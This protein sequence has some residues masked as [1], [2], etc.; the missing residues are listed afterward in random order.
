LIPFSYLSTGKTLDDGT[1]GGGIWNSLATDGTGVY[2]TTGNTRYCLSD[3][4]LEPVPNH[5]LGMIRVDKDTGDIAWS[6]QPVPFPLDSDPDWAAGATVM[7][8]SC[9]EQIASVQK[10]GWTYAVDATT[11][12]CN[13]AFPPINSPLADQN[14][15]TCKGGGY[16]KFDP[17]GPNI[18]GDDDYKRP[19]AAWNDVLIINTGGENLVHFDVTEDYG[20]LHALNACAASEE[21]RVRWIADLSSYSSGGGYSIGAPTVSNGL[22]FVGTDM[23]KLIILGDPQ[24]VPSQAASKV[25]SNPD[26]PVS[27]CQA[28]YAPVLSLNPLKVIQVPDKGDIAGL[29]KEAALA[30][31]RI[32]VSTKNGHVYMYTVPC[33]DPNQLCCSTGDNCSAGLVCDATNH[34]ACGG[35]NQPCCQ[36]G[37]CSSA[38]LVC[39]ASSHCACGGPNE[40]CCQGQLCYGPWLFCDTTTN[41]CVCGGPNEPCCQG[42]Q[43][44]SGYVCSGIQPANSFPPPYTCV[45]PCGYRGEA[46]CGGV[47]GSCFGGYSCENGT[48]ACGG[49]NQRCCQPNNTCDIKLTCADAYC[50]PTAGPG[51]AC[52]GCGQELPL[53]LNKCGNDTQCQCLCRNSTA[54]CYNENNCGLPRQLENCGPL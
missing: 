20:K 34:C 49:L 45:L 31:G 9:G 52:A 28:P 11:G 23:G 22:V 33:G 6:F 37:Q 10:D 13:W 4:C 15:P 18:H 19:G 14:S 25:C 29:R 16:S 51:D 47:N 2:F 5:G 17:Q 54:T 7:A 40:P 26:Y 36:G 24:V 8:T 46:C 32:F 39:D 41:Y 53:C 30:K 35:L 27:A 42:V 50:H 44:N 43:C 21:D 1:R 38:G 3:G 12:S 48:C